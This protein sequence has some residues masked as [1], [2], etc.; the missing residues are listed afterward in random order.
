MVVGTQTSVYI[1]PC[2]IFLDRLDFFASCRE[3]NV[4]AA[5]SKSR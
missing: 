1:A 4:L 2:M 5:G 3:S